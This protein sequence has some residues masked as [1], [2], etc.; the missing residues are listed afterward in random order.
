[1]IKEWDSIHQYQQLTNH[2]QSN[3][4]LFTSQ[5][6]IS[7]IPLLD[8]F[9]VEIGWIIQEREKGSIVQIFY[10]VNCKSSLVSTTVKWRILVL[11]RF[12]LFYKERLNKN[13]INGWKLLKI[14][15]KRELLGRRNLFLIEL[16]E[17]RI[18]IKTV[19]LVGFFSFLLQC[20]LNIS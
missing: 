2:H 6:V 10:S 15:K 8:P 1:M 18:V 3:T 11:N 20:S 4:I 7:N 9:Q 5:S 16:L 13:G 19:H 12:V 17:R 14:K